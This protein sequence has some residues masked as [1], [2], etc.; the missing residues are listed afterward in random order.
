[1]AKFFL[2]L[3]SCLSQGLML[4]VRPWRERERGNHPK[5]LPFPT[6]RLF[7]DGWEEMCVPRG[8]IK[9]VES[10]IFA[11]CPLFWQRQNTYAF[12]SCEIEIFQILGIPHT[13]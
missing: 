12:A 2:G 9:R 7:T 11:T 13:R 1:M 8:E 4:K 3:L 10:M 6:L 5:V